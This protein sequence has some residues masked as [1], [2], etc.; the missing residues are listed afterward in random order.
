MADT[1]NEFADRLKLVRRKHVKMAHGYDCKVGRDGL[2]VFRPKRRKPS[3]PIKGLVL[4]AVGF[5]CF[6]GL[7]MA[8]IGQ[9]VYEAR[10]D[11]LSQGTVFEQAGA[12]VMQADPVATRIAEKA[13][14]IFW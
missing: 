14:P 6:K 13:A 3:F 2:I 10:V 8:Q 5:I 4:L 12:F 1:Q 9:S 7:V 11:Q